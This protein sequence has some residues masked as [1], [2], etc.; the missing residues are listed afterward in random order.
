MPG[1]PRSGTGRAPPQTTPAAAKR[2]GLFEFPCTA[3]QVVRENAA[4]AAS[5]EESENN[6]DVYTDLL[7]QVEQVRAGMSPTTCCELQHRHH[8]Q[9]QQS[10]AQLE[11]ASRVETRARQ[12]CVCEDVVTVILPPPAQTLTLCCPHTGCRSAEQSMAELGSEREHLETRLAKL[13]FVVIVMHVSA[14]VRR[15]AQAHC[16]PPPL[17]DVLICRQ[18]LEQSR[19]DAGESHSLLKQA[20][21]KVCR[22]HRGVEVSSMCWSLTCASGRAMLGSAFPFLFSF[23]KMEQM[24]ATISQQH[25]RIAELQA[26]GE[27]TA[28]QLADVTARHDAL[29]EQHHKV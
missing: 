23:C 19:H 28:E 9:L 26:A 11:A 1:A 24:A 25:T 10:H 27:R 6:N 17:L 7:E 21:E 4:L 5:V 18:E 14:A 2:N 12:R 3:A 13:T 20:G 29:D 8:L 15:P 22:P 16:H